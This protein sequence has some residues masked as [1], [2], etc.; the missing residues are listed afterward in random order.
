MGKNVEAKIINITQKAI[1]AQELEKE[2]NCLQKINFELRSEVKTFLSTN[3]ILD[4][5]D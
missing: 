1:R 3:V 5:R 4:V 2:V